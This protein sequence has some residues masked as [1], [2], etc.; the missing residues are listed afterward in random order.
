MKRAYPETTTSDTLA[1]LEK[2][3]TTFDF[4]QR[5]ADAPY[6]FQVT[7]LNEKIVFSRTV[8]LCLMKLNDKTVLHTVDQNTKFNAAYF[9]NG[10]ST[11]QVWRAFLFI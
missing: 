6:W 8:F 11:A 4:C 2:I 7:V 10:E 5:E 3:Q 9:L 1:K